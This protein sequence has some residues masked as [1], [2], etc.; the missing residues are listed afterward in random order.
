MRKQLFL[1]A[2]LGA[3]M[4]ML[5][6]AAVAQAPNSAKPGMGGT[7]QMTPATPP[8]AKG[9]AGGLQA[10]DIRKGMDV[11]NAKGEK[12]GEVEKV[13]GKRVVISFGGVLG[14]GERKVALDQS[15]LSLM[16]TGAKAKLQTQLSEDGL[17]RLPEYKG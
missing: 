7:T 14:I 4:T 3:M 12:I 5:A 13:D 10:K 15:E 16:G 17:K 9:M 11:V 6:G 8:A 1:G 2:A